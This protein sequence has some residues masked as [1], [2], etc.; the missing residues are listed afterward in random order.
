[1]HFH[2][3]FNNQ[4]FH[5]FKSS[6]LKSGIC[7]YARRSEHDKLIWCVMEMAHFQILVK[8]DPKVKAIISNLISRLKIL[9]MEDIHVLEGERCARC[10]KI[11]NEYEND[12]DQRH[13]L[14]NFCETLKY[15]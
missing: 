10:I 14:L 5:G 4:S 12:R 1:M 11:L 13:L 3:C 6:V 2:T 8:D 7:K 9:L 15:S